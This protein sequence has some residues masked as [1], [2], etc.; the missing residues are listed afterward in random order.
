MHPGNL[1]RDDQP[2]SSGERFDTLLAHRNLL[3]ERIV[4]S[5]DIVPGDYLQEQDEWVV[6]LRGSATLVVDGEEVRLATGDYLFL[7]ARTPH[8]VTQTSAGA[9]W[10]AIHL[11]PEVPA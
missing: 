11:R 8:S 5:A 10:L 1:F 6:L 2:P 3:V 9:L 7:P 4:S